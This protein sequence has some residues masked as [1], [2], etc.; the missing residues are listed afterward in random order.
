MYIFQTDHYELKLNFIFNP[1]PEREAEMPTIQEQ[2]Q[3]PILVETEAPYAA[4]KARVALMGLR[5][6]WLDHF[7]P[8]WRLLLTMREAMEQ[9]FNS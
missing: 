2:L 9:H 8:E 5:L 7:H 1:G 6:L 3:G 4:H